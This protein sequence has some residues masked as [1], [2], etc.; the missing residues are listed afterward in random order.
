MSSSCYVADTEPEYGLTHHSKAAP[1]QPVQSIN[2]Y[3]P[4]LDCAAPISNKKHMFVCM[5]ECKCI[6][7]SFPFRLADIMNCMSSRTKNG[8]K[9]NT[10]RTHRVIPALL[11]VMLCFHIPRVTLAHHPPIRLVGSDGKNGATQRLNRFRG[12]REPTILLQ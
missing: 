1:A 3:L 10:L 7:M 4:L 8:S 5:L 9:E 6:L 12:D 11:G 2:V